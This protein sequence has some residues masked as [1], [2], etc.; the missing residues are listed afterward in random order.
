MQC[1][2]DQTPRP[3]RY[4]IAPRARVSCFEPKPLAAGTETKGMRYTMLGAV[5]S[6][7]FN[8]LAAAPAALCKVVWEVQLETRRS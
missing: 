6:G 8:E 1:P 2:E 5:A 3:F 4:T 7:K